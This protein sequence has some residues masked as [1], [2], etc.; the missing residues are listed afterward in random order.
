VSS[1][2]LLREGRGFRIWYAARTAPPFV[3]KYYAIGAARWAGPEPSSPAAEIAPGV[4]AGSEPVD[5]TA[6]LAWQQQTREH[7]SAMLGFPAARV[8]LAVDPRGTA[9]WDG[10]TIERM[11]VAGER[12]S[13]L[14]AVLYRPTLPVDHMPGLVLT[15]GHG[16]SKSA[17]QYSYAGQ[18]YARLGIAVLAVDPIGEEERHIRGEMGTRAHDPRRVHERAD[19][20]GRL[21]MGKLVWDTMRGIDL[22]CARGDVDAAR[23]GVAGNSLGGA[24][25]SWVAALDPRVRMAIVSGW[26]YD[27]V[28][29]RSKYC[30]R[31]PMWR[32]RQVCSWPEFASL[33]APGCALLVMNGDAD[34]IIDVD[35]DGSAWQGTRAVLEQAA[36]AYKAL[37]GS[38]APETW[39]EAGGGH[40]PY[41]VYRRAIEWVHAHLG[42]PG[43]SLDQIHALHPVNAGEWCDAHDLA[44]EALYGT[45]LHLRGATLPDASIRPI[46]PAALA[47]LHPEE[48]GSAEFT[49]EGW[50]DHIDPQEK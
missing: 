45:P 24:V 48:R 14:P 18:L 30:T 41:F 15:F 20:A 11:V 43:R 25:A 28:G 12:G 3:H 1:H 22:L 40:R 44:L 38:C 10:V 4:P 19:G 27:D 8:P 37:G 39:F 47:C 5:R 21:I 9:V 35:D 29:L 16:G 50:L 7:L 13:R 26:A 32:M 23:V 2:S 42:T 49:L 33:A 17:W 46:P 31:V 6:F 36:S 34:W